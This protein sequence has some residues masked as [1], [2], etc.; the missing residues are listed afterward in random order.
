MQNGQACDTHWSILLSYVTVES[1]KPC[2][3]AG[4]SMSHMH[5]SLSSVPCIAGLLLKCASV[6]SIQ[7]NTTSQ[8]LAWS[9][10]A[11]WM[12][13]E[14]TCTIASSP[15]FRQVC[16]WPC[17]TYECH[18]LLQRLNNSQRWHKQASRLSLRSDE[19]QVRLEWRLLCRLDQ[20][21]NKTL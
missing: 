7:C 1:R 3:T 14:F 15:A 20:G 18:L 10:E 5:M 17:S 13:L 6:T 9:W 2:L 12:S 8:Q 16:L 11:V 19:L 21:H 4:G